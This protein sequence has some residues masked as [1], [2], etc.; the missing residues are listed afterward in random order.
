MHD[1]IVA[2]WRRVSSLCVSRVDKSVRR[3][4]LG[5][6]TNDTKPDDATGDSVTIDEFCT[7]VRTFLCALLTFLGFNA[8]PNETTLDM[9]NT[10]TQWLADAKTVRRDPQGATAKIWWD[11]FKTMWA[12]PKMSASEAGV[13]A[14]KAANEFGKRFLPVA[15]EDR[16][17]L[18]TADFDAM[19]AELDQADRYR[20]EICDAIEGRPGERAFMHPRIIDELRAERDALLA[21]NKHHAT[22]IEI[23]RRER[24]ELKAQ[25]AG[26]IVPL[27]KPKKIEPGQ[28]WAYVAT[29]EK[30]QRVGFGSLYV[31]HAKFV[32]REPHPSASG[33]V[34]CVALEDCASWVYLGTEKV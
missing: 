8:L 5:A 7:R 24:D 31:E 34:E 33:G 10:L 18:N 1:V 16:D 12:I 3:A 32:K 14:D 27:P 19:R 29:I 6:M 30:R 25:L 4:H 20:G 13:Y 28:K 22:E 9:L 21:S 26:A 11:A 2:R 15:E 17:T 23:V